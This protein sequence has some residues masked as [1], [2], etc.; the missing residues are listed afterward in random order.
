MATAAIPHNRIA[1]LPIWEENVLAWRAQRPHEI[2]SLKSPQGGP[3][4]L[5]AGEPQNAR[6]SSV[7][8][9][10]KLASAIRQWHQPMT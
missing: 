2:L 1:I 6:K 8:G 10:G 5:K 9:R 4:G 7:R 3:D